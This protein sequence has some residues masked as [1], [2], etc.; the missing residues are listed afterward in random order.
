MEHKTDFF[1]RKLFIIVK[2][3][4]LPLF[5]LEPVNRHPKHL[6]HFL[7]FKIHRRIR[8]TSR[9]GEL[10]AAGAGWSSEVI[11]VIEAMDRHEKE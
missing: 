5:L 9:E 1:H 8:R 10:S 3:D 4:D 11:S 2:G 6:A 7:F